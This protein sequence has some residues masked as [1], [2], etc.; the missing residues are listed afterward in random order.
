MVQVCCMPNKISAVISAYNEENN[1]E[2]CLQS[3]AW[4]NEIILIDNSSTDKTVR[5]AKKFTSKI[6][7]QPNR[8]MLNINKNYGFSKAKEDWI[9]NLDADERVSSEL[10]KEIDSCLRRNDKKSTVIPDRL[11]AWSG[12]SAD[13][14]SIDSGLR[15]NDKEISG[16]EMPRKNIIFGKWI[17]H[18]IWWPDYQL[19]LFKKEKGKFDCQHVHEKLNLKGKL[20]K[21]KNPLV[22]HNYQTIDQ[23]IYKFTHIYTDSEVEN[24]LKSGKK[25]YW[26]DVIRMPVDDFLANF[27]ARNLYKEGLHGLVLSI[28]QSFYAFVV[29]C[30]IWEKQKFWKYND[31]NFVKLVNR[32]VRKSYKDYKFW[33]KST[34][35]KRT[36][37]KLTGK[38]TWESLRKVKEKVK[39][40]KMY[41]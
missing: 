35:L 34:V 38:K 39:F 10:R 7:S 3:V 41:E 28:L 14:N 8:K 5:I 11:K 25:V 33:T 36:L 9:L 13:K 17:R 31:K 22:H 29:F 30:K 4:C 24:F 18:G 15:R 16:F 1:I 20:G 26:W 32:Q 27:L 37:K 2:D 40:K 23:Y 21:L 6:Y 19:R 12:I